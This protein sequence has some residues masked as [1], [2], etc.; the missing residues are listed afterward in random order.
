M[1]IIDNSWLHGIS[2]ITGGGIIENT[3][4]IISSNQKIKLEWSSWKTPPIFNFIQNIGD[5]PIQDMR[6]SF[7]LGIGMILIVDKRCVVE[8]ENHLNHLAE[9]YTIIGEI[10]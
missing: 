4:R 5:V 9:P 8:A 2:H 7:N 6:R 3:E 10:V 1:P